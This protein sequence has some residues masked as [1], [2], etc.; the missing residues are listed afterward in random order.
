MT[1]RE[2]FEQALGLT[3]EAAL[4]TLVT[5]CA[6]RRL[7]AGELVLRAGEAVTEASFL[8]SGA[9]RGFYFDLNGHEVTDCFAV[10]F[11][12][13]ALP[14]LL[15]PA[16]PSPVNIEALADTELLCVPID[17][18][19]GCIANS[20]TCS[21]IYTDLVNDSFSRHWEIK[22]MVVQHSAT[23]R[24]RWFLKT[25]PELVG[26]AKDRVIASFLGMTPVTL[27]RIKRTVR[28]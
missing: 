28:A 15:D 13:P 6:H 17:V 9:L 14:S 10:R 21:R 18:A 20:P 4:E 2:F 12:T 7:A 3:D 23:D 8:L 11:G 16:M 22:Q 27:S 5:S 19:L 25:Y 24:Y 26:I 1:D